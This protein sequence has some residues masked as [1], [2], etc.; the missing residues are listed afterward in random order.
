MCD[1]KSVG[2][3]VCSG[4]GT[5]DPVCS[6]RGSGDPVCSGRSA[7]D[8]VC[9]GRGGVTM[10]FSIYYFKGCVV[11]RQRLE[12]TA[13]SAHSLV[14]LLTIVNSHVRLCTIQLPYHDIGSWWL[15]QSLQAVRSARLGGLVNRSPSWC[16]GMPSREP[17]GKRYHQTHVY[18]T[19]GS[20]RAHTSHIHTCTHTH[21]THTPYIST[22]HTHITHTHPPTHTHTPHTG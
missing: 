20:Q 9:S 11:S 12:I 7:G 13:V 17:E 22:T 4:R 15:P 10:C 21:I 16:S 18:H 19:P 6:G 5:G 3:L 2:D 8:P 1:E 14:K